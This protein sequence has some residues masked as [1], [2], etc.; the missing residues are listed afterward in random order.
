MEAV[1][2]NPVYYDLA[3]EM[4]FHNSEVDINAWLKK[5]IARRYGTSSKSANEAWNILLEGPY[6]QGTNGVENSS[7]IC[8]R[9]AIDVKKS[10][11]NYGFKIPYAPQE[12]IKA[13]Q[14]LLQDAKT[15]NKSDPYLFD[16][17]DITRQVLT[18]LGQ[19]IH[20]KAAQAFKDKNLYEFDKF[21]KQFLQLLKDTDQLLKTRSE[22][23]F[24]KWV[25]DARSWGN[26]EK[27]KNLYE[28]NASM[29]VTH[30]GSDEDSHIFDY[31]WREW[32][33]LIDGYY[34]PRWQKFYEMLRGHLENGTDYSEEGLPQVYERETLRANEF[35]DKLADWETGWIESVKTIDAKPKGN[36]I[37]A[38]EKNLEKYNS[39]FEEYYN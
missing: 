24:D 6:R 5:S 14:L 32:S 30:W 20:K 4:P 22:F 10:G 7:I 33:G 37:E 36:E 31:S 13:L 29:L 21:S 15:L 28:Y 2:Q 34:L 16:I 9:P 27:E 26:T 17:V 12:L 35:Y 23:S 18:N 3:F 1:N 25:N 38:V 19:E 8:A 11:P 39:F